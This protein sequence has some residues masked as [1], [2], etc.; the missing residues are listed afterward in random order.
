MQK[1]DQDVEVFSRPLSDQWVYHHKQRSWARKTRHRWHSEGSE[2]DQR[3]STSPPPSPVPPL[4]V[5]ELRGSLTNLSRE[6]KTYSFLPPEDLPP[7]V[8]DPPGV[9]RYAST[10]TP[11]PSKLPYFPPTEVETISQSLQ[12]IGSDLDSDIFY[13]NDHNPE[14]GS[15]ENFASGLC[16]VFDSSLRKLRAIEQRSHSLPNVFSASQIDTSCVSTTTDEN[17]STSISMASVLDDPTS[18][19]EANLVSMSTPAVNEATGMN[20]HPEPPNS[21]TSS[22]CAPK[23]GVAT[24]SVPVVG[25]PWP[26]QGNGMAC[27]YESGSEVGEIERERCRLSPMEGWAGLTRQQRNSSDVCSIEGA[28]PSA[29]MLRKKK[30]G[31][32]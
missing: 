4:L 10:S 12:S 28:D 26:A 17:T 3:V 31:G 14:G 16:S 13:S 2:G 23:G 6:I 25:S 8:V 29:V 21:M 15:M 18:L 1:D 20:G 5:S 32:R 7:I 11:S 24:A 19:E 9:A 27:S 22:Y 30:N